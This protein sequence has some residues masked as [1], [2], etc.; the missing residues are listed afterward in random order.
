MI[1][2]RR[3]ALAAAALMVLPQVAEAL[4]RRVRI[5]NDSGIDIV[6]FHGVNVDTREWQ[7]SLLG[8]DILPA[9]G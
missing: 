6:G 8:D 9:G 3:I 2:L 1:V 7:D 5:V 4:D